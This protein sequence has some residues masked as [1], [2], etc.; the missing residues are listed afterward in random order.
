MTNRFDVVAAWLAWSCAN[1]NGLAMALK[2]A[3]SM[4]NGELAGLGIAEL[5]LF[6]GQKATERSFCGHPVA[7]LAGMAQQ[8][9]T[10]GLH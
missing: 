5:H 8:L 1:T 7:V 2:S 9:Q 4:N 10:M 6:N 3:A